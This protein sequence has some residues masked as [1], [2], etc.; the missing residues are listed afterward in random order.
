[1]NMCSA[2]LRRT[3]RETKPSFYLGTC[4]SEMS[5]RVKTYDPL[6]PNYFGKGKCSKEE[7]INA[8]VN[9]EQFLNIYK[10]WQTNNFQR[11]YAPSIDRID[12]SKGYTLDNLQF[13]PQR[14][15]SVKDVKI[16]VN[17]D[18]GKTII[19]FD[20]QQAAADHIG[21]W[22]KAISRGLSENTIFQIKGYKIWRV[23]A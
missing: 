19:E 18:D 12:N 11:K 13:I 9:N 21:I 5:R 10:E 22:E 17:V 20:S 15:N 23:N 2:C 4:Y 7:F 16:K 8:F 14:I 6:R 1:M 3:K